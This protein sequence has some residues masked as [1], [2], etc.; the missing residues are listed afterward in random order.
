MH[1]GHLIKF[2]AKPVGLIHGTKFYCAQLVTRFLKKSLQSDRALDLDD[3]E[4]SLNLSK[5]CCFYPTFGGMFCFIS[6]EKVQFCEPTIEP[7]RF[8]FVNQEG[9]F[10]VLSIDGGYVRF[11]LDFDSRNRPDLIEYTMIIRLMQKLLGIHNLLPLP[12]KEVMV[13]GIHDEFLGIKVGD[14]IFLKGDLVLAKSQEKND[15]ATEAFF[16]RSATQSDRCYF[17]QPKHEFSFKSLGFK[18]SLVQERSYPENSSLREIKACNRRGFDMVYISGSNKA[19]ALYH[20]KKK[21][22][23]FPE[24]WQY[25]D[26]YSIDL[27]YPRRISLSCGNVIYSDARVDEPQSWVRNLFDRIPLVQ[28]DPRNTW[29]IRD[30]PLKIVGNKMI[31]FG[32]GSGWICDMQSRKWINETV[33]CPTEDGMRDQFGNKLYPRVTIEIDSSDEKGINILHFVRS[34]TKL[35]ENR[36]K[37]G[38]LPYLKVKGKS[39]LLAMLVCLEHQDIYFNRLLNYLKAHF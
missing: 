22:I 19:L 24:I 8:R 29:M 21:K 12:R 25:Q 1:S 13:F 2:R 34:L 9:E 3:E 32:Y 33:F 38:C 35:K 27:W 16:T 37:F 30:Q 28:F 36:K 18:P 6:D 5:N 14:E 31:V 7:T 23:Q 4:K 15:D 26:S 11:L 10:H 17:G 39:D 20:G